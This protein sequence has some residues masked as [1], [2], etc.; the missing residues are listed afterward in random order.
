MTA[1]VALLSARPVAAGALSFSLKEGRVT[2]LAYGVTVKEIL[3]EW[4]RF[5]GVSIVGGDALSGAPIT[6][7]LRDVPEAK[8]LDVLLRSVSGYV[9]VS[10]GQ[11]V[12]ARS[13]FQSIRILP[14]SRA[15]SLPPPVTA[16]APA[17]RAPVSMAFVPPAPTPTVTA[18]TPGASTASAGGSAVRVEQA[19]GANVATADAAR[20]FLPLTPLEQAGLRQNQQ[21]LQEF[22]ARGKAG[23]SPPAPT[24]LSAPAVSTDASRPG[25]IT[26]YTPPPNPRPG[27]PPVPR[28]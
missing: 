10:R 21:A 5:G 8:A 15:P 26:P 19:A 18:F 1:L 6:L 17:P 16:P 28:P 20:R 11:P 7:E 2:I 14:T 23:N 13:I 25:S 24:T 4:E 12:A 27:T 9:A 22:L 3:S